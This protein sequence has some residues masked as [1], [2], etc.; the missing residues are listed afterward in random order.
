LGYIKTN[1]KLIP[2]VSTNLE[3]TDEE[4]IEI[5]KRRWDIEQGYKEL[6]QHFGFGKEENHIYEAYSTPKNSTIFSKYLFQ[7]KLVTL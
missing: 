3:L 2:L 6:R 7:T 4:V 1:D 5:Y